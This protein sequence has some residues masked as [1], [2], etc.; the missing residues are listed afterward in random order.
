MHCPRC[1][2]VDL[3]PTMIEEY[4]PA[5]ACGQCHGSFVSLLYYR[6]W[7]ETYKPEM[8]HSASTVVEAPDTPSALMCPKCSRVMTKFRVDGSVSNRLDV[9]GTCDEAWLDGG[10]W[11]LLEHLQLSHKLPAIFTD[12][13]QRRIRNEKTEETRRS[14]LKTTLGEAA[15]VKVEAFREWLNAQKSK[16]AILTYLYRD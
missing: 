16:S 10:E 13:W 12:T 11:E 4:L 9:C 3:R 15:A 6:H 7:A 1:K 8:D 5:M 14:I 2:T